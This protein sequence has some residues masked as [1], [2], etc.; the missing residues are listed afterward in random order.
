MRSIEFGVRRKRIL[1]VLLLI[2]ITVTPVFAGQDQQIKEKLAALKNVQGKFSFAVIGDN[3]SGDEVYKKLVSAIVER[4]PDFVVNTGDMITRPGNKQ[5]WSK[6]W[7]M[8]KPITMPYFLTVGNHD[9][10]SRKPRTEKIYQEEVDLPG[11]KLYY[12]FVV[13]NSLFIVLDT[14]FDHQ[15]RKIAGAQYKWLKKV[16]ANSKRKHKFVFLHAPLYTIRGKGKHAGDSLDKNP[17]YRGLLESLFVQN[18]V[19]MVFSGHEHFYQRTTHDGIIHVITGGGGAP[20]YA[21]D[22]DGGFHHYIL[23]TVDGDNVSAEVVDINGTVRD[24]F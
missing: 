7:E 17:S 2:L 10:Y 21:E 14:Y 5:D 22:K 23:V 16:L 9:V 20:L 11:N 3:R 15:M 18:G 12:S 4:K 19:Q 1:S 8:S 13:G 24:R 6:F